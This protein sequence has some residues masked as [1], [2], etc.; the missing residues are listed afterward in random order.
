M[1]FEDRK[2]GCSCQGGWMCPT[3]R[4]EL[5]DENTALKKEIKKLQVEKFNS[6]VA[7]LCEAW[8]RDPWLIEMIDPKDKQQ[9]IDFIK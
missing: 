2:V 7:N 1:A 9:I 5:Q 8:R 4:D 3:C 6:A